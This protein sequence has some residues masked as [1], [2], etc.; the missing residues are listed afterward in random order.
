MLFFGSILCAGYQTLQRYL[1][2]LQST[3]LN[4]FL[5]TARKYDTDEGIFIEILSSDVDKRFQSF[6]SMNKRF[7]NF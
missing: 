4:F 6:L 7:L 1:L 3:S 5:I 2:Q